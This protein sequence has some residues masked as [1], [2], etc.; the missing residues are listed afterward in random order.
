MGSTNTCTERMHIFSPEIRAECAASNESW[1]E[2]DCPTCNKKVS[3]CVS[4]AA[5]TEGK[6]FRYKQITF[7]DRERHENSDRHRHDEK[8]CPRRKN[9]HTARRRSGRR[10]VP[11]S[12]KIPRIYAKSS[13]NTFDGVMVAQSCP[14]FIPKLTLFEQA[15]IQQEPT[16]GGQLVTE[17]ESYDD[18][19]EAVPM[20]LHKKDFV[21]A[22]VVGGH[23]KDIVCE[24]EKLAK[25]GITPA[26]D[27]TRPY[28]LFITRKWS[29]SK[30]VEPHTDTHPVL[31]VVLRGAK[32]VYLGGEIE[33][34]ESSFIDHGRPK[35]N[36]WIKEAASSQS[37]TD[38]WIPTGADIV[39][40]DHMRN[41]Q[42]FRRVNMLPGSALII[43]RRMLHAVDT[44]PNTVMLSLTLKNPR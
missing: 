12:F 32:C 35:P 4:C 7:L 34:T 13:T 15:E 9:Q 23:G 21:R 42:C 29:K 16:A 39:T 19:G 24:I 14:W 22:D 26:A 20:K 25:Q 11:L 6:G 31:L 38:F 27:N 33:T 28:H 1:L 43:P 2:V 44:L 30:W 17:G 3:V 18:T 10:K 36:V 5:A 8:E 40:H 41:A 37:T